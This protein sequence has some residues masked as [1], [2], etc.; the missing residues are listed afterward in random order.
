M[1]RW[2]RSDIIELAGTVV[3]EAG[4]E[5]SGL[6]GYGLR[7]WRPLDPLK[8]GIILRARKPARVGHA[9]PAQSYPCPSAWDSTTGRFFF[10]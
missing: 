1:V 4:I 2:D 9:I 10:S 7:V 8:P 3:A 5:W 6:A